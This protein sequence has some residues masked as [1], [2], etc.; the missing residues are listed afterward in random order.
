MSGTDPSVLRFDQNF[1]HNFGI[2]IWS[3]PSEKVQAQS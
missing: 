1:R 2:N 3:W